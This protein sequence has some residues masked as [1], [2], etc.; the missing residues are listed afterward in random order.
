MQGLAVTLA[1][2][3]ANHGPFSDLI[4]SSCSSSASRPL[5]A[6][7]IQLGSHFPP[8]LNEGHSHLSFI[9]MLSNASSLTSSLSFLR[10][11]FGFLILCLL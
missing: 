11:H 1:M 5:A 4:S 9:C 10:S 2:Q 7:G 3:E 8:H 6:L